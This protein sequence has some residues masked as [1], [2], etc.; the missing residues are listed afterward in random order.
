MNDRRKPG[1]PPVHTDDRRSG[2]FSVRVS[3]REYDRMC[4][5]A[6]R[7]GVALSELIRRRALTDRDKPN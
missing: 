5:E 3:F 4:R 7:E 1:R 6:A 2:Y